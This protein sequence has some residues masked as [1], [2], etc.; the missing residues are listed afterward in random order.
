MNEVCLAKAKAGLSALIERA[1]SGETISITRR[2]KPV[3]T[4][5]GFEL[6]KEKVDVL[7]LRALTASL[8]RADAPDG[9]FIQTLRDDARY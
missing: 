3:A 5:T 1:R 8:K 9:V 2:G 6:A 7:K 4:L